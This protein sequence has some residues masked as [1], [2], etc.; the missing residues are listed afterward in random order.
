MVYLEV[1]TEG[2]WLEGALLLL[3]LPGHLLHHPPLHR[4]ALLVASMRLF[5]R[6]PEENTDL[7]DDVCADLLVHLLVHIPNHPTTFLHLFWSAHL[8]RGERKVL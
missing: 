8:V 3:L 7:P 1:L 6:V 2:C 5:D 4:L